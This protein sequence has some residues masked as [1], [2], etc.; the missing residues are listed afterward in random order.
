LLYK[1]TFFLVFL[2][3]I[4]FSGCFLFSETTSGNPGEQTSHIVN[5]INFNMR[6]APASAFPTGRDDSGSATVDHNFLIAETQVTYELWYEVRM[7]AEENGY[8]F[9]NKGREGS[10]GDTGQVPSGRK[11]EPVTEINW[12]DSIVWC[13]AISEMLG[14]DPVYTIDGEVLRDSEELTDQDPHE[15]VVA[16]DRNGFRLPTSMEWELAARYRGSDSSHGAIEHPGESGKYWTPGYYVSGAKDNAEEA[17]KAAAWYRENSDIDGSGRK[18]QD[19]GQ[20]PEEG[21]GLGVF[22]MS[23]NVFEW[24]FCVHW[25]FESSRVVRGGCWHSS[26][27]GKGFVLV[28][29]DDYALPSLIR[30]NNGVRLVR[31]HF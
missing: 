16:E 10:H 27:C 19:V 5:G 14:Y 22:D 3:A 1:K 12:Y 23:G 4:V 28:G 20:K 9:A 30:D 17:I 2:V 24:C 8:T 25:W 11:N 31:T 7:W 13:N 6:F 26:P 29:V 15:D 21:N 18:T